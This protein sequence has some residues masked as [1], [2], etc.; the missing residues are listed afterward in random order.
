MTAP[1]KFD[2]KEL[3]A[4]LFYGENYFTTWR[5]VLGIPRTMPFTPFWSLSVEEQFYFGFALFAWLFG[6]SPKRVLW[7]AIIATILPLFARLFYA[8]TWPTLLA[9]D[10]LFIY[11]HTET[12]IDSIA[13]GVL[14]AVG[15]EFEA[16]LRLIRWLMR[17]MPVVIA[18]AV[19]AGGY[20]LPHSEFFR[21][22]YRFTL[23]NIA[24]AVLL[25]AVIFSARYR[26]ANWALNWNPMQKLG[27]W[28]YSV[29]IWHAII[30]GLLGGIAL[31]CSRQSNSSL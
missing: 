12:R 21:D 13:A 16:G 18:A 7:L 10:S 28:S 17:P 6:N 26:V 3:T 20:L 29:Y 8:T 24:I 19:I 2:W 23:C 4:T 27:V 15:C 30:G 9:H 22:T 5:Q 1:A 25:P 31:P 11:A 14:V